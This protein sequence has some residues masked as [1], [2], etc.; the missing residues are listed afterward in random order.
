LVI[1]LKPPD[2]VDLDN[3]L[4]SNPGAFLSSDAAKWLV[5][6][7]GSLDLFVIWTLLLQAVGYTAANPRKISFGR[8]LATLIVVWILWIAVK[9]GWAAAFA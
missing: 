9:V 6:L 2:M 1:L 3:L 8:A 4:A 7:L 5:V